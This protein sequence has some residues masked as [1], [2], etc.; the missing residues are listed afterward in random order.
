MNARSS[1][2]EKQAA[3]RGKSAAERLEPAD[4]PYLLEA[5]PP[6]KN[7]PLFVLSIVLLAAWVVCLAVLAYL[8]QR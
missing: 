5:E 3:T 7:K 6:R 4:D 1:K 8:S 2:S